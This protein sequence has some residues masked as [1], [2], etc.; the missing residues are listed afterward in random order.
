MN[1]TID[2]AVAERLE[3]GSELLNRLGGG[4]RSMPPLTG[5]RLLLT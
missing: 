3:Q 1:H 2:A 4:V 5:R